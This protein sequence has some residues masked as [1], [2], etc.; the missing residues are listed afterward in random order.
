VTASPRVAAIKIV[1]VYWTLLVLGMLLSSALR[2]DAVELAPA[3]IGTIA[4]TVL[5]QVLAESRCRP[6]LAIIV[7]FAFSIVVLPQLPPDMTS[8]RLYLAFVPAAVSGYWSL[9]DRT[10]LAAFWFPAMIW[11][12]SI[13]DATSASALPDRNGLVLFAGLVVMFVVYLRA[14][15]E[16]RI[17]LWRTVSFEPVAAERP[18][19]VLRERPRLQLARAAWVV[20]VTALGFAA[21]AW[22]APTLWAPETIA[23]GPARVAERFPHPIGIPC[24]PA[25]RTTDTTRTRIQEYLDLGRAHEQVDSPHRPGIDCQVCGRDLEVASGAFDV[26]GNSGPTVPGPTSMT[27]SPTIPPTMWR[28]DAQAPV[29]DVR[30]PPAPQLASDR[31]DSRGERVASPPPD[32]VPQVPADP[33]DV[34]HPPV[35]TAPVTTARLPPA[36]PA[37][38]EIPKLSDL[39]EARPLAPAGPSLLYWG[40][41][42][43]A[44]MFLV[45]LVALALRPVR[46]LLVLRHLREPFWHETVDQRVSNAWQLVLVGLRDAGWRASHTESAR[47]LARRADIAGALRCATILERARHGIRIDREDLADMIS[48]AELG[49][50]DARM[51]TGWFARAISWLRWPLV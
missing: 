20:L 11:M 37:S 9:G 22:I 10:S 16:R 29:A 47:E 36:I 45:Q 6:W 3:W 14:R 38:P 44:A 27:T 26:S 35:V 7:I 40:A 13:L 41:V 42:L 1:A 46:R 51:R 5:G 24:C 8:S 21:T 17:A 39:P 12:L 31:A 34:S 49:Y 32:P 18:G 23:S 50:R 15:E 30:Q 2:G 25:M 19:L 4:G 43:V 48:A 33:P 28:A